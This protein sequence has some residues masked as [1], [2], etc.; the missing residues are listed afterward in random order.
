MGVRGLRRLLDTF[1][2]VT[3][4]EAWRGKRI[5]I[6]ASIW[7]AQFRARCAAGDNVEG[8]ILE[9]F[10][11]RILKLL[12]YGIEPVFVFDGPSTSSKRAEHQRRAE[13][14][15]AL[16]RKRLCHRARQIV[17]AQ[18]AAGALQLNALQQRGTPP[19]E[20]V[21]HSRFHQPY[22]RVPH[23]GQIVAEEIPNASA[24][25]STS[26]RPNV[27]KR[28]RDALLEPDVVSK[29]M[30]ESFL[31][32]AEQWINERTISERLIDAN[33]LQYSSTSLFMGPRKVL[34]RS[35]G[36]VEATTVDRQQ[37][38]VCLSVESCSSSLEI[39]E[40][41][42]AEGC[43][44]AKEVNAKYETVIWSSAC[45]SNSSVLVIEDGARDFASC[46]GELN[47]SDGLS[48]L[49]ASY[50]ASQGVVGLAWDS[51]SSGGVSIGETTTSFGSTTSSDCS[52]RSSYLWCP[53][54]QC[55][56]QLDFERTWEVGDPVTLGTRS[57]NS[58]TGTGGSAACKSP[59]LMDKV[60]GG[61]G[62]KCVEAT[63]NDPLKRSEGVK[64]LVSTGVAP[65]SSFGVRPDVRRVVP[66]E[67]LEIV[68]LL[69]C[70]GI[71]FIISPNEADAQ[72][73]YLNSQ[74]LVDAVFTEDS[75]VIVH[76]APTVLRGFFSGNRQVVA[77][78]QSDLLTCGVDKS[79]L[80]ALAIL[81]GC[82]YAEGVHGLSLLEALHVVA[83]VW[84]TPCGSS[85]ENG[86]V[87]VMEML[88]R[89]SSAVEQRR[90]QW[91]EECT[92]LQFYKRCTK[93]FA[94]DFPVDFPQLHVLE[95]FF[96]P[97]IDADPT[98]FKC[99]APDWGRL[100][101]FAGTH[102]LLASNFCRQLLDTAQKECTKRE[103]IE[104]EAL[105]KT[106]P[107]ITDFIGKPVRS[108]R[109]VYKK[110]PPKFA[111]ALAALRAAKGI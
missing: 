52:V 76:G 61:V 59:C 14:R 20:S 53:G 30:T 45:S 22:Q 72:C 58:G 79:V 49:S 90:I 94:L 7:M 63:I 11:L 42:R 13:R 19:R 44:S 23:D 37:E 69:D 8:R 105:E 28:R 4:P 78:H 92:L 100:R 96:S 2:E 97:N 91:D 66:F 88:S 46:P 43:G 108:Q 10:F 101:A 40:E 86:A 85:V 56:R 5:A 33:A 67:L 109:Y 48:T 6:D 83:S 103:T 34:E 68:E 25:A 65:A 18:L 12:F 29:C 38:V 1:G 15:A 104:V 102:G 75:D 55:V 51:V 106:Q 71:P 57:G 36:T 26:C 16:E 98:P 82:D 73:A 39:V 77:Y 111:K 64:S 74:R 60:E 84:R 93:W 31:K 32:D 41:R 35:T 80:V 3:Q 9:G 17:A 107:R 87:H 89:W 50:D 54:T 110:Q 62:P 24:R 95:A 81:L 70:C 47:D 27:R 21:C 99:A